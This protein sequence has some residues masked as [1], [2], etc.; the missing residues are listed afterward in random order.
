MPAYASAT[1]SP[2]ACSAGGCAAPHAA[3]TASPI[4]RVCYMS[5]AASCD[6]IQLNRRGIK[7]H[8]DD[9]AGGIDVCLPSTEANTTGVRRV[10]ASSCGMLMP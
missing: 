1:G 7:V 9:V 5:L 10:C 4:I 2:T 8:V 6:A 3:F